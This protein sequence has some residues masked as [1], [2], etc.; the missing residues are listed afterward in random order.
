MQAGKRIHERVTHV[1]LH[2]AMDI[3]F[4]NSPSSASIMKNANTTLKPTSATGGSSA[5][6]MATPTSALM[7]PPVIARATPTPE[8]SATHRPENNPHAVPREVIFNQ[9]TTCTCA[10]AGQTQFN[11]RHEASKSYIGAGHRPAM[12]L[13]D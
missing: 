3:Q 11:M 2:P 4:E 9:K 6:E 5:A 1:A 7:P 13:A 10:C 8:G 12:R